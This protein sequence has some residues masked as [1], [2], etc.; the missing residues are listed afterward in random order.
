MDWTPERVAEMHRLWGEMVSIT[1]IARH[2][3]TTE[4]AVIGKSHRL[5]LPPR[6]RAIV[7]AAS[8]AARG[9]KLAAPVLSAVPPKTRG[10]APPKR[11]WSPAEDAAALAAARLGMEYP[12]IARALAAQGYPQR[13]APGVCQRVKALGYVRGWGRTWTA[14]DDQRVRDGYQAGE[15]LAAIGASLGRTAK[16]AQA[17]AGVLGLHG[18]HPRPAGWRQETWAAEDEADLRSTYGLE[19]ARTIAAR[20]GRSA[21]AVWQRASMLGLL[22]N[23]H[24]PWTPDDL[25]AIR[26]AHANGTSIMDLADA[27][28][29]DPS[30]V[31]RQARRRMGLRFNVRPKPGGRR[32][33]RA[34]VDVPKLVA[35]GQPPAPTPLRGAVAIPAGRLA[36][37]AEQHGCAPGY[38][39]PLDMERINVVRRRMGLP[40]AVILR[41]HEVA[42]AA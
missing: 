21:Q 5:R 35:A 6:D 38:G 12:A 15:T 29:R 31:S 4:S 22:S 26:A 20:L 1:R 34:P 11:R 17:R 28:G 42:D 7:K 3:G 39:Q 9:V 23:R 40:P 14:A 25:A 8:A 36:L 18:S 27:L 19:P 2:F 33:D 16:A 41:R 32:A 37:W 30:V 13:T 24:R 10:G